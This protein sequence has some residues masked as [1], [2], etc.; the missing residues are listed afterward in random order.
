MSSGQ[1]IAS[2][3]QPAIHGR[4]ERAFT[5]VEVLAVILVP[6]ALTGRRINRLEGAFLSIVYA[7][8]IALAVVMR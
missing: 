4:S 3:C 8:Y 6:I 1:N 5:L 7:A 2:S